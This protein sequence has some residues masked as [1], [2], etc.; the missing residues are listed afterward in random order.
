MVTF[1]LLVQRLRL[2]GSLS[3]S[4]LRPF[5][6]KCL[7]LQKPLP[8]SATISTGFHSQQLW[9]TSLPGWGPWAGGPG[10]GLGSLPPQ[11][12]ISA[13]EISLYIFICYM[14]V[15]EKPIHVSAAPA[16]LDVASSLNP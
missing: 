5:K 8:H 13:A 9:G 7:G 3:K 14:W 10:V 4:V 6:R 15:W 11:G 16:S 12:G 2:R 1:E